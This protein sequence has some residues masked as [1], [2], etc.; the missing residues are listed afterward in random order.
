MS[1]AEWGSEVQWWRYLSAGL[2]R[3]CTQRCHPL[4]PCGHCCLMK[5]VN[6]M[7]FSLE[8]CEQHRVTHERELK[9]SL[10]FSEVQVRSH[11]SDPFPGKSWT[12]LQEID[13]TALVEKLVLGFDCSSCQKIFSYYLSRIPLVACVFCLSSFSLCIFKTNVTLL[14]SSLPFGS[15]RL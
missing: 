8:R 4:P 9:A 11:C 15:W 7:G 3:V 2:G 5:G 1:S 10:S 13:S 6:H 14:F 12:A